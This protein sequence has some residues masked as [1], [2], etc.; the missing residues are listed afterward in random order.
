MKYQDIHRSDAA[1]WEQYKQYIADGKYDEAASLIG[2]VDDKALIAEVFNYMTGQDGDYTKPNLKTLQE[3]ANG[4]FKADRIQVATAPPTGLESGQIYFQFDRAYYDRRPVKGDIIEIRNNKYRV[5]STD[6]GLV[7]KVVAFVGL[8]NIPFD[9]HSDSSIYSGS[10][11]DEA[12]NT[13][14]YNSLY[15]SVKDA[16]IDTNIIQY[17]YKYNSSVYNANTHASYADYST[18]S[19]KAEVGSRHIYALDVEDIEEYFGGTFSTSDIWWLF[20]NTTSKPTDTA[21]QPVWLR[22]ALI[23]SDGG[24]SIGAFACSVYTGN[25]S[26]DNIILYQNARP[27]FQIDLSQIDYEII[28]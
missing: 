18:K 8:N 27:A 7:A 10:T 25:I 4:D 15:N 21:L 20:W 14:Y 24:A 13:T 1:T 26:M 23:S 3:N 12:L 22:S 16:I 2:E 6:G 5:L 17:Q 28:K 11:L 19:V 9:R